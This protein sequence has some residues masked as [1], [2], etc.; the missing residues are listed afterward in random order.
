MNRPAAEKPQSLWDMAEQASASV[1]SFKQAMPKRYALRLRDLGFHEGASII[2][3]KRLPFNG[4]MVLQVS[5]NVYSLTKELAVQI[6]VGV[7]PHD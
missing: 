7:V 6:W 1:L 5:D 3:L 4:P 2:C